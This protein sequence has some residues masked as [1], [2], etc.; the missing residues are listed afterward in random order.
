[1]AV[2][3]VLGLGLTQLPT[4]LESQGSTIESN[5]DG[6]DQV[7]AWPPP[8]PRPDEGYEYIGIDWIEPDGWAWVYFEIGGPGSYWI[9]I[10]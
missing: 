4:T 6:P 1:M 7:G 5:D 9:W 8:H 2:T 3:L 10:P